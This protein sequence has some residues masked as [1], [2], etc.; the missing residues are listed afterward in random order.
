MG[1][2]L[3]QTKA[4]VVSEFRR[5]QILDA[6]RQSFVRHGFDC[7]T[8]HGIARLAGVAKGTVYLYYRSKDDI[9]QEL[10]GQDLTEFEHDTVPVICGP[11]T[12][13]ERLRRFFAAALAFFDRK[14]DFFENCQA[15][16]SP[17]VRRKTRQ[18][19]GLV[20]AAQT[21]AWRTALAG[22]GRGRGTRSQGLEEAAHSIV[23]LAHGLAIQRLRGWS[24]ESLASAVSAAT[25]LVWE[26][27]AKR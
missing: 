20:F 21:A 1:S 13:E 25:R 14:R 10:V 24:E 4:A 8:V 12:V 7:T 22:S 15:Q 18:K 3:R 17:D 2:P 9:L 19:L 11:G 5:S 6:A 16:M 26:G 27:L 23:S